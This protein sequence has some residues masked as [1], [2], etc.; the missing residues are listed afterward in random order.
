LEEIATGYTVNYCADS[1]FPPIP[2]AE[3]LIAA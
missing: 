2:D 3:K 1:F